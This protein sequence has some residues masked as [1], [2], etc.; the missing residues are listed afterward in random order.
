MTQNFSYNL[1][2]VIKPYLTKMDSKQP[3]KSHLAKTTPKTIFITFLVPKIQTRP[4]QFKLSRS[5]P[6]TPS[7]M[8]KSIMRTN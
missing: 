3:L 2:S 1:N 5:N 8:P 6:E 4:N 7:H